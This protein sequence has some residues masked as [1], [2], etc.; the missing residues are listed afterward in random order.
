[1]ALTGRLIV[2]GIR[3]STFRN[4]PSPV[5]T[6]FGERRSV[7]PT[8]K[9]DQYTAPAGCMARWIGVSFAQRSP[10][11]WDGIRYSGD[12]RLDP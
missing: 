8:L 4:T 12:R 6:S 2:S 3:S 7:Q 11:L 5:I 10:G 9:T 1:M